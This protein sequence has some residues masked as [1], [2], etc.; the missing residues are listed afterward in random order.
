VENFKYSAS[1]LHGRQYSRRHVRRRRK[2]RVRIGVFIVPLLILALLFSLNAIFAGSNSSFSSIFSANDPSDKTDEADETNQDSKIVTASS[3]TD[4]NLI[5]VNPWNSIPPG[6]EVTLTQLTNGNAVDERCY[7][8]LQEMMDDCRAAG[9][10]P[11]IC[12]SYR[13]QE[14]QEQLYYN[15]IDTL[16]EQGYSTVA[17]T[18]DAG[19]EVAVPGTSEHQLGLAVDIVDANNQNLDSSQEE[20]EVQQWLMQN[21]W[22][23]GFILRY[24]TD[25]KD[26][27]GI[28]YEPW[29]YR[30]VGKENA[31]YIYEND[32]CLEE[33]L[34][35]LD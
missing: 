3:I 9:C 21:S 5:L 11:L 18:A 17:A 28:T 8:D 1:G 12:S 32:L 15:E 7:P 16:V 30:Y 20:T 2:R 6:Y 25:K 10:S 13:S 27:T 26:I 4:W 19:K 23:Y 29:H 14:D 24:P 22:K 31:R 33:Y 35:L 34:A